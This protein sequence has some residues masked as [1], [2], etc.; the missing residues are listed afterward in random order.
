MVTRNE[1]FL[2]VYSWTSFLTVYQNKTNYFKAVQTKG[3][4]QNLKTGNSIEVS[5]VW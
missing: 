2:K 5:A 4:P 3:G 1:F